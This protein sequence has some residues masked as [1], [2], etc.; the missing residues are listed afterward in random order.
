MM[1]ENSKIG[2]TAL[3]CLS[4]AACA[5]PLPVRTKEI[6]PPR[7]TTK[8]EAMNYVIAPVRAGAERWWR[9]ESNGKGR[10]TIQSPSG[11][12]PQADAGSAHRYVF[13]QGRHSVNIGPEGYRKLRSLLVD[14]ISG[15]IDRT[16]L[17]NGNVRC[18]AEKRDIPT[19]E[20]GWTHPEAGS[21]K[22]PFACLGP[23]GDEAVAR[24]HSSW[25]VIAAAM[26]KR[27]QKG[28]IDEGAGVP[29]PATPLTIDIAEKHPWTGLE[30]LWHLAPDGKGWVQ[31]SD[32]ISVSIDHDLRYIA[33][34]RHAFDL[35]ESGAQ[36]VRAEFE[37]YISGPERLQ[38][39]PVQTTDQAMV[40]VSWRSDA[41]HAGEQSC[42]ALATRVRAVQQIIAARIEPN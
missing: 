30:V 34:G 41:G 21:F 33:K 25:N 4:L 13:T 37:P 5:Q 36:S 1:A 7:P 35:G 29:G 10:I 9:I 28:V 39:C 6:H 19:A 22:H 11:F 14:T 23:K 42:A 24:Y 18:I 40:R 31:L 15:K 27:G 8:V 2:V 12:E 16:G 3:A 26:A 38:E 32:G 17:T 20:L